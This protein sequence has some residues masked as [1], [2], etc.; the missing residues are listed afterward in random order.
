[1]VIKQDNLIKAIDAAMNF[2]TG[3]AN[4]VHQDDL[5]NRDSEEEEENGTDSE[6]EDEIYGSKK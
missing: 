6:F 3:Y 1:M 2:I 5:D 4:E